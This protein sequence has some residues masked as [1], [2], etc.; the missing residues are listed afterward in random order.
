MKLISIIGAGGH[1]RSSINL[2]KY[3]FEKSSLSI[4]DDSYDCNTKEY[5]NNIELIGEISMISVESLVFLSIGDNNKREY[6]YNMFK[7]QIIKENLFHKSSY[8]EDSISIGIANQIFANVYINSCVKIGD[9]N[10]LNTSS[11]LEH[12]SVIGNHNHISV[13]TK[14]CGRV[15]IGN[16]CLIGSGA[17]INDKVSICNDVIIGSGAVVTK[18]IIETGTYVGVPARRIK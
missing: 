15:N 16:R 1:T 14:I 3:N 8:F 18:D 17:V 12:E 4:F 11:I 6:Y 13:G 2:L 9:D 7:N 10:I 5:I